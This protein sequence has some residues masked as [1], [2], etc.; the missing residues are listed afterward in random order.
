VQGEGDVIG[1][2]SNF[3]RLGGCNLRCSFCDTKYSWDEYRVIGIR[4]I[5][6]GLE[7]PEAARL[8]TITGG[9]PLL[10]RLEPLV[11]ELKRVGYIVL[12]ETNGTIVPSEELLRLVDTWSISP[13]LSNSCQPGGLPRYSLGWARRARSAYLKFV[14]LNPEKDVPEVSEF[15]EGSG[16][17]LEVVLQPDG[18]REDY[19]EA[20]RELVDYVVRR[21]LPYRVLPQLHRLVY[22]SR[23]GA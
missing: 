4:G 11:S 21:R 15:L 1:R 9:E 12:V 7:L 5:M 14:I 16:L 6:G 19:V 8:V 20:V 17:G 18:L 10:Q 13:K 23:R 2:L 22:G 3:I